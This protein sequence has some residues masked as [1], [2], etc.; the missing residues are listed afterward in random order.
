MA[1]DEWI[2]EKNKIIYEDKI[3]DSD[4]SKW[5]I[6]KDGLKSQEPSYQDAYFVYKNIIDIISARAL[7][8]YQYN[9][10]RH[11]LQKSGLI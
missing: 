10:N 8:L 2:P 5:V 9:I 11:I 1:V 4:T 3:F 6:S 7:L